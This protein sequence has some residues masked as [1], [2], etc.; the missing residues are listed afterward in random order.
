M[1]PDRP[2]DDER[3]VDLALRGLSRSDSDAAGAVDLDLGRVEAMER[4][5]AMA[6]L[7]M[8]DPAEAAI[9]GALLARLAA[10]AEAHFAPRPARRPRRVVPWLGWPVAAAALVAL[11]LSLRPRPPA[12]PPISL[13][14]W[15][16]LAATDHPLARGA[17]GQIAWD[18]AENRGVLKLTGLAAV[19]PRQGTYQLWIIDARR[20]PRYPVDGGTFV[21]ADPRATTVVPIRPTL[22]VGEAALYAVTLEPPGGVVVSDR[23]RMML[24]GPPA[25]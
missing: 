15:S 11:G 13:G 25:G 8:I 23:K 14:P 22:T 1:S 4:A 16:P 6:S 21:V 24:A 20:D 5:A 7:A 10:D 12:E 2:T 17:A 18:R 19:D 3:S 9:P